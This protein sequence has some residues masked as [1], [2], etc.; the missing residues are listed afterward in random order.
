MGNTPRIGLIGAGEIAEWHVRALRAA[1]CSVSAVATRAGSA[2]ARQF[3]RR[4][5]IPTTFD[6]WKD[7]LD[8]PQEWDGLVI[9][10]HTDVTADILTHALETKVPVLVEKPVAWTSGRIAALRTLAHPRVLVGFNRRFYRTAQ[11]ARDAVADGAPLLAHLSLP[12]ALGEDD[13]TNG[14]RHWLPFLSNSCH[15]LDLLRFVFGPLRL[16][17]VQRLTTSGGRL[18]GLG[19]IL[20]SRR[21]DIIQLGGNWGSAANFALC[22]DR[23]G[24]RV[25]LRPFESAMVYEGMD[26]L[27]PSDE[28]PIRR[29]VPRVKERIDLDDV[30]RVQ[31]PGFVQQALAFRALF[32]GTPQPT[33]AAGLEDAEAAIAL[34]EQL[35][36]RTYSQS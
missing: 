16:E 8:H 4:H 14:R 24:R 20:S 19:A 9:A 27:E 10:T 7:L 33:V 30:D 23:P 6:G 18:Y 3:A 15:G 2:R 36:G 32:D 31:K 28:V 22:L 5:C 25:E 1:G 17:S 13:D 35:L 29:Y 34:A 21:G 26:V 11:F 12:E